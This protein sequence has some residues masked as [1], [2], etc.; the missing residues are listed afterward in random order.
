[1]SFFDDDD[2]ENKKRK[3]SSREDDDEGDQTEGTTTQSQWLAKTRPASRLVALSKEGSE[4]RARHGL[5]L[6]AIKLGDSSRGK[7]LSSTTSFPLSTIASES[8][9]HQQRPERDQG[10]DQGQG[11]FQGQFQGQGQGQGQ[12]KDDEEEEEE[13]D[14]D[15]EDDEEEDSEHA[16][17]ATMRS[18]VTLAPARAPL[19]PAPLSLVPMAPALQT[20]RALK[21]VP[22]VRIAPLSSTASS[23]AS[24]TSVLTADKVPSKPVGTPTT[25]ASTGDRER[26]SAQ[27][28]SKRCD[29]QAFDATG[30]TLATLA[31]ASQDLKVKHGELHVG[32]EAN[33]QHLAMAVA[34]LYQSDAV[35]A[36]SLRQMDLQDRLCKMLDSFPELHGCKLF[37]APGQD[38]D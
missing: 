16:S 22:S 2:D 5:Q 25:E 11:K 28:K 23:N 9:A 7:S 10:Q 31:K 32:V 3:F 8:A 30:L 38:D 1:M 19:K 21:V 33:R 36:L 34:K 27:R 13:E 35:V 4:L 26:A 37:T 24:S 14:D 15:N 17:E 20:G 6:S 12:G 29:L 18:A